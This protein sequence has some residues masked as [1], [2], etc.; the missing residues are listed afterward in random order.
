MPTNLHP[1]YGELTKHPAKV[2]IPSFGDKVS[3]NPQP[4]PPHERPLGIIAILIG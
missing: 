2:T 3:L 4:L 1:L